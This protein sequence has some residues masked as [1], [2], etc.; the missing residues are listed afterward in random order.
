MERTMKTQLDARKALCQAVPAALFLSGTI[1][2]C[3]FCLTD[4]RINWMPVW[5]GAAL[6]LVLCAGISLIPRF[7]SYGCFRFWGL[8]GRSL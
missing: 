3:M 2:S 8:R 1:L 6:A 5:M 4:E 7:S